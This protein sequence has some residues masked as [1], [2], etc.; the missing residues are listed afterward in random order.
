MKSH[1]KQPLAINGGPKAI[2]QPLPPM[3]PG[4]MRIGVE[5][6]EAV[7]AVLRNKR[8]FR[9][10][11]PNPGESQAAL[12][13]QAFATHM[14]SPYAIA[15]TSG[16]ASLI[17]ALVGLGVGPGDEV[18]VPAYTWIASAS[19]VLAAGAIPVVAEVDAS[20]TL[21]PNDLER[22]ITTRTRVIIAVHM[23][24]APCNL[25]AIMQVAARHQLKVLEDVA[26]A[27]GASYNGQRLGTIGDAGAFSF[28]FN[29]IITAGEGGMILTRHEEVY[30]RI[31]M[32]QDVVGGMRNHIPPDQILPGVNYRMTELQA[33]VVLVQ[34]TKLESL[35]AAMRSNHR[36][37]VEAITPTLAAKGMRTRQANDDGGDASIALILLAETPDQA[38]RVADALDAEGA[39]AGVMYSPDEVDYHIYTHWEPIVHQRAWSNEQNPWTWHGGPFDYSPAACPASLNLLERAIHLNISPELSGSQC[40]E[41]ADAIIRV[42]EALG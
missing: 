5:E 35:L 29:K 40:E 27:C 7:L 14:S 41:I 9:Y 4:G 18:I 2:S 42:V 12:L 22:R 25:H 28:Q 11:G 38:Q 31:Q 17:C 19:A 13:E 39:G 23:R 1:I 32:Y 33:A 10:Y 20:L 6:E 21:D 15:V 26:Q 36:T 16:T 3:Y 24:G 34:L 30:Q 37:I 8:L